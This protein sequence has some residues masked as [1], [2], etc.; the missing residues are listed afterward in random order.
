MS[1]R[2]LNSVTPDR[3]RA[4]RRPTTREYARDHN[5]RSK[6]PTR[7]KVLEENQR[8]ARDSPP[9]YSSPRK[10]SARNQGFRE[11]ASLQARAICA[12]CLGIEAHN[13]AKCAA[14]K[15]W[16][17]SKA[18]CCRNEEG[19]IINPLGQILCIDWQRSRGCTS[20]DHDQRHECSGC[21]KQDHG[22]Q[23]C[24]RAQKN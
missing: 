7:P 18:R 10:P 2:N 5:S 20:R 24:P 11:G 3:G 17:G 9:P 6:S 1:L 21:G 14:C 19:R 15:L 8:K 12:I 23:Q 22:A 16:D 13:V 4:H